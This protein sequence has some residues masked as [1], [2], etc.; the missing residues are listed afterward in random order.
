MKVN[1]IFPEDRPPLSMSTVETNRQKN[2][3]LPIDALVKLPDKRWQ[4]SWEKL[5]PKLYEHY[6]LKWEW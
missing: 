2:K 1:V 4:F 5:N 6:V 3:E